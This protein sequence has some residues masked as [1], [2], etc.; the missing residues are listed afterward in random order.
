LSRNISTRS[1][2][3]EG[4]SSVREELKEDDIISITSEMSQ[5]IF[6][7]ARYSVDRSMSLNKK[8]LGTKHELLL[9]QS[10]KMN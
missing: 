1:Q 8:S 9:S 6:E 5:I 7:S 4:S 10:I 2:G 3:G